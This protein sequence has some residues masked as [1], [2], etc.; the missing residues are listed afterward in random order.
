MKISKGLVTNY[1]TVK[2]IQRLFLFIKIVELLFANYN[3]TFVYILEEQKI[4][5]KFNLFNLF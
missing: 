5:N 2:V 1:L 3:I 4:C